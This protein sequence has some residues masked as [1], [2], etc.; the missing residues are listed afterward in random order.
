MRIVFAFGATVGGELRKD[1]FWITL[2]IS[3]DGNLAA[4]A[5]GTAYGFSSKPGSIP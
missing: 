2:C 4:T 5:Y 1:F 3:C